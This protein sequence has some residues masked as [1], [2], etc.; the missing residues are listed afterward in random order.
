MYISD[1]L[2]SV[3]VFLYKYP[4]VSAIADV[5]DHKKENYKINDYLLH[6]FLSEN[7]ESSLSNAFCHL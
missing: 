3:Y 2:T 6:L 7:F 1:L 5:M 4:I